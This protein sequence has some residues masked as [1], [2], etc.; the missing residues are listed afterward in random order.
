MRQPPAQCSSTLVTNPAF[1]LPEGIRHLFL[2]QIIVA[3][4]NGSSALLL[5]KDT[6]A[7]H[8]PSQHYVAPYSASL[9]VQII[10]QSVSQ[11]KNVPGQQ[12]WLKCTPE[13][14]GSLY[15]HHIQGAVLFPIQP[16]NCCLFAV[17]SARSFLP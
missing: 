12:A 13:T 6:G 9:V 5:P 14:G 15:L 4:A 10:P 2:T 1:T 11:R 8:L 16:A 3:A 7:R 17:P